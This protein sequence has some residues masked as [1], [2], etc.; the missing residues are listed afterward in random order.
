MYVIEANKF[1]PKRSEFSENNIIINSHGITYR[2]CNFNCNY[3]ELRNR[4]DEDFKNFNKYEF[5]NE[6][7][8]LLYRGN[9]FKFTGGEPTLNPN[10]KRDMKIVKNRG[11]IIYLDTNGSR[12][13]V[14]KELLAEGLIDIL[15]LS[16]KGLTKEECIKCTQIKNP[17]LAWNCLF[18]ILE[19][20]SMY[21]NVRTILTYVVHNRLDIEETLKQ[22]D[23]LTYKYP[24]I[25]L[26]INNLME[27][28]ESQKAGL[29]AFNSETLISAVREFVKK[30]P[31][32]RGKVILI[33]SDKAI[34]EFD[35]I[36]FF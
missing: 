4:P 27:N 2:K 22:I 31:R 18:E 17:E 26:K 7:N 30:T 1:A 3:C 13:F 28:P 8:K 29:T 24:N 34:R 36:I 6:V 20:S 12:P 19:I 16:L 14:V 10:L 32:I 21:K 15:G 9:G 5:E 33:P 25:Y 35:K 11:G 23:A